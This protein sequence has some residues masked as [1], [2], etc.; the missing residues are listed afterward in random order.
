MTR[1]FE[2]I[3]VVEVVDQDSQMKLLSSGAEVEAYR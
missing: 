1:Q 2:V 3:I